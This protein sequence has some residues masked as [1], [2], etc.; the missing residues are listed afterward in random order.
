MRNKS[1]KK[2]SPFRILKGDFDFYFLKKKH[3]MP[4]YLSIDTH[5]K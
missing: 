1:F 2:I 3:I 5:N 4:V